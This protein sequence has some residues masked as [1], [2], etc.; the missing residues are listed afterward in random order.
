MEAWS[1]T[2]PATDEWCAR[3]GDVHPTRTQPCKVAEAGC[4]R[5]PHIRS[6]RRQPHRSCSR[7]LLLGTNE[8]QQAG[9]LLLGDHPIL[10]GKKNKLLQL[11]FRPAR[12]RKR[13]CVFRL[14]DGVAVDALVA[15]ARCL[16]PTPARLLARGE[17]VPAI[18]VVQIPGRYLA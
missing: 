3:A 2:P 8:A 10:V 17:V 5:R 11:L 7:H 18:Y 14:F 6:P 1:Q 9:M 12:L 16:D 13:V 15:T 4:R